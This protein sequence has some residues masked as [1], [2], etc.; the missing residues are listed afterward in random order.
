M[1]NKYELQEIISIEG[2][3][4]RSGII[5]KDSESVSAADIRTYW[6]QELILEK[7]FTNGTHLISHVH[8]NKI[9]NKILSAYDTVLNKIQHNLVKGSFQGKLK[10]P[11]SSENIRNL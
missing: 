7:I 11:T 10:C 8:N 2:F 5:F 3:P 1:I 4:C 6:I 9:I